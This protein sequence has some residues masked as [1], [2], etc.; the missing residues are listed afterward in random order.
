MD[1]NQVK[2]LELELKNLISDI[3]ELTTEVVND[4]KSN[5]SDTS[6][7]MIMLHENSPYLNEG[8][9]SGS[10]NKTSDTYKTQ[11]EN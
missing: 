10:K 5:P 8:V 3:T 1:E 9:V 7:S 11:K 6:G 4:Y 2:E